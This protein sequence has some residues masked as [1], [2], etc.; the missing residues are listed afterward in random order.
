MVIREK[1][2]KK[3]KDGIAIIRCAVPNK[4]LIKQNGCLELNGYIDRT[5]NYPDITALLQESEHSNVP[6]YVD[7][8]PAVVNVKSDQTNVIVT[9]SNLTTNTVVILPK[10]ILCERQPVTVTKEENCTL[11][12]EHEK[13]IDKLNIDEHRI[14]S[15]E[16]REKLKD[17]LRTHKDILSTSENDI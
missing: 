5:V 1:D 13:I 17:L 16:Q 15:T 12:T 14:S 11:S 10:A 6:S 7:V 4:V 2:L 3:N 9:L 8:T